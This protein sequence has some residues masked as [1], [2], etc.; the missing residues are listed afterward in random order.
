MATFLFVLTWPFLRARTQG[1]GER[2][3]EPLCTHVT[4]AMSLLVTAPILSDQGPTLITSKLGSFT[5]FHHSGGGSPPPTNIAQPA[6]G[7]LK[8][9]PNF[10]ATYLENVSDS[11]G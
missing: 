7:C 10:D 1:G 5:Q 6:A 9:Q 11:T 8:I 2:E 3:R 4:S